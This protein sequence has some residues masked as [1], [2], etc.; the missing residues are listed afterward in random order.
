MPF[1]RDE[2]IIFHLAQVG[3]PKASR[4]YNR[5]F[6]H[7]KVLM[8]ICLLIIWTRNVDTT[9]QWTMVEFF[10]GKG[11][12]SKAF[13]RSGRHRVASFELNDSASMDMNTAPGFALPSSNN[14]CPAWPTHLG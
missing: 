12:V 10:S 1:K 11:N 5:P 2:Y 3:A 4:L 8:A 13:R 9:L 6:Q 14:Q 7:P